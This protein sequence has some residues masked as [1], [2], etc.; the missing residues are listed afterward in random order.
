[1]FSRRAHPGTYRRKEYLDM[2]FL[3]PPPA[4]GDWIGWSEGKGE[5]GERGRQG[6]GGGMYMYMC[7]HTYM[8]P[9]TTTGY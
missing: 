3:L 6:G 4:R 2:A 8:D 7:I 9:K 1:M 5:E